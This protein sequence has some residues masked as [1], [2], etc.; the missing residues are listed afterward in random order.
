VAQKVYVETSIV[1]YLTS[2]PSRDVIHA[3]HQQLTAAWWQRR[4]AL[5]E[6]HVSELVVAE[7]RAGD[8][9][10]ATRRLETIA[11]VPVLPITSDTQEVAKRLLQVTAL[12]AKAGAD[13][14]HIAVATVHGMDYLLTWNCRHIANAEMRLRIEAA[15]REMG[16]VAPTLCT[17]E[18]LMGP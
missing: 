3:A 13:A 11:S 16:Y 8:A 4:R 15:C 17:P 5:F 9:E 2:R 7:S 12:P 1:S 18:E 6:I 10:A 14:L